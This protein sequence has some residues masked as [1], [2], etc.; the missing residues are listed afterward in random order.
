[1]AKVIFFFVSVHG[2]FAVARGEGEKGL[3]KFVL[4]GEFDALG[5][6][7]LFPE[8]LGSGE[9]GVDE[10]PTMEVEVVLEAEAIEETSATDLKTAGEILEFDESFLPLGFE[11]VVG[12]GEDVAVDEGGEP[13]ID[14]E[15]EAEVEALEG[16]VFVWIV[17]MASD[18][19][20][21][22][23]RGVADEPV[24][25][26]SGKEVDVG[27]GQGGGQSEKRH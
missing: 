21:G 9:V 18:V 8:E 4:P 1:M 26:E 22:W 14:A 19:F 3:F 16:E 10:V 24:E 15:V 20:E 25:V 17:G 2:R 27:E 6:E 23:R 13:V 5:N 7:T 11:F 12:I